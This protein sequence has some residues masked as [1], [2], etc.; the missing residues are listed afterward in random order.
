M[1][2]EGNYLVSWDLVFRPEV[3][4]GL[5]SVRLLLKKKALV[6]KWLWWFPR[7]GGFVA[8]CYML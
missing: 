3:E 2:E 4:G 1:D 5:G 6:G 8:S 7:K